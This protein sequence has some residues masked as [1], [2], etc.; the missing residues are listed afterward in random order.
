MSNSTKD[1]YAELEISRNASDTDIKKSYRELAKKW[2]PDKNPSNREEAE[3]KFKKI[4]EAYGILS[5]IEKKDKYDKYGVC[6]GDG[7]SFENGYPDLS[8]L[9][10]GFGF[11][12]NPFGF[13]NNNQ[14]KEAPPQEVILSITVSDIVNGSEKNI[15]IDINAYCK[16]CSGTG[17]EDKQRKKCDKCK[18]KGTCV[19]MRQVGPGMMAQQMIACDGCNKTGYI[20]NNSNICKDCKGKGTNREKLNKTITIPPDF[21]YQTNM[22]I[23]NSGNYDQNSESSSDIYIKFHILIDKKENLE[24]NEYDLIYNYKIHVHD[25]FTGFKMYHDHIDGKKYLFKIDTVIHDKS[26]KVVMNL[27]LP[28]NENNKKGRGNLLIK[29]NYIY[30]EKILEHEDYKEF[31]KNRDKKFKNESKKNVLD[32]YMLQKII[33]IEKINKNNQNSSTDSEEDMNDLHSGMSRKMF[34]GMQR[35]IP[36]NMQRGMPGMQGMANMQGMPQNMGAGCPVQ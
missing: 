13:N 5:D 14:K 9:L 22:C 6:D 2:H 27:G 24:I 25:A 35:G 4:S 1:Y 26:I 29:F 20:I 30:P 19:L 8:D 15:E 33:D 36:R 18:G 17:S 28:Y 23:R 32:E 31:I 7:P 10:N 11:S 34:E 16:K 21:D 3:T 12:G